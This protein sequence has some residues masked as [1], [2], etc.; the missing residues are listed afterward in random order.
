MKILVAANFFKGSLSAIK[1][2]EIIKDSI[3]KIDKTTDVV[4]IP[5]ADGGDGTLDAIEYFASC[6]EMYAQITGPL[7]QRISARWLRLNDNTAVIEGAQ[8]NGLSLLKPEEYNPLATTTYGIGELITR[9]LDEECKKIYVTIGGSSTNDG[10]VGIIHALGGKFSDINGEDISFG[11]G[12]LQNLYSIDL[13]GLDKRLEQTEIICA[14]DVD[15]PLCGENGASFVYAPQK[16]AAPE[17][18]KRLEKGLKKLADITGKTTGRDYRDYPGAGAAGGIGFALK[19]F[20]GADIIPGF[21]FIAGLSGMQEKIKSADIVITTEGRLDSQT[22]R[23]KAPY[24]V[25]KMAKKHGI[26]VVVL[27]GSI[28]RG[29]D[30]QKAG[31]TSAFSIADGPI[32]LEDTLNNAGQL[33]AITTKQVISLICAVRK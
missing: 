17:T 25:V 19:S 24:Q 23:G 8:A 15:N 16:G 18:V 26:P 20:L 14:S 10:G 3:L 4:T 13:S 30:I 21:D 32:S 9:A 31:I 29:L 1:A 27:A 5:V 7:G 6:R 2:A 22:L 12:S 11:G 28:E 33:L